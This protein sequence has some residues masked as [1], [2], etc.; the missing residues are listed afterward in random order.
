LKLFAN[1]RPV[2]I[3]PGLVASSP[4]RP[5]LL[6]GVDLLL[7]RELTAGISSGERQEATGPVGERAAL[8]TLPYTEAEIRRVVR[9]GFELARARRGGPQSV[10]KPHDIATS[11]L[12]SRC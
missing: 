4:L 10:A 1:L 3:H 8:D 5:E 12:W 11:R 9:L 6:V 7:F 2:T